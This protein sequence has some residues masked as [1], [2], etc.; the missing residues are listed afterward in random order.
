MVIIIEILLYL[1]LL[2]GGG[3]MPTADQ[4]NTLAQ[5]NSQTIT[6]ISNNA[7]LM[8]SIDSA[9]YNTAYGIAI[10]DYDEATK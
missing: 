10:F 3:A 6:D 1:K 5:Q 9:Y 8:Q 2:S 4:I 7:P